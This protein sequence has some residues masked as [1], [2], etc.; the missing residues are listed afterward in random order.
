MIRR[1]LSASRRPAFALMP[2][3]SAPE[4]PPATSS[5]SASSG[6]EP[7]RPGSVVAAAKTAPETATARLPYRSTAGP[8]MKSIAGIEPSATQRSAMPSA[9]FETPV[10][11]CTSGST[12]A[13]APQKSPSVTNASERREPP[14]PR[15]AVSP[16]S[17]RR[18]AP[19]VVHSGGGSH[20]SQ[21]VGHGSLR[22]TRSPSA[23]IAVACSGVNRPTASPP[24]ARPRPS[25]AAPRSPRAPRCRGR[26]RAS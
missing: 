13:H 5:A 12:E 4:A 26:G 25:T 18:A 6:S 23:R 10:A 3:S 14:R 9:P 21:P 16:R 7:A 19:A 24:R 2:T 8:A 22:Q 20:S 1:P 17:S 15:H 11:R